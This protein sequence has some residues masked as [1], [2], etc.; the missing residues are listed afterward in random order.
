MLVNPE[1]I[2]ETIGMIQEQRLDIRAITMG[3]SLR[4][5]IDP[6]GERLCENIYR[7]IIESAQNLVDTAGSLQEKYGIPIVNKRVSVSPIALIAESSDLE[8]YTPVAKALD[9]AAKEIGIDFIGG[10]TA[11]VHKGSTP[12]DL[13]LIKS[14]P[15]A[16]SETE[17]L[18]SSVNVAS[19][20][21]GINM[22]AVLKMA[23]II[24]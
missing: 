14:I 15:R 22:D 10:F 1:E 9:S 7:K 3:I 16:L 11:L 21:A 2:K 12:G 20:K 6:D 19:S 4:D 13:R 5:C 23:E 24:K 18:C 8:D 17:R